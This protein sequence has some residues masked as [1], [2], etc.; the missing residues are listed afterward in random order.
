MT[1]PFDVPSYW[2]QRSQ[3]FVLATTPAENPALWKQFLDGAEESYMRHGVTTALEI[4]AIRD[5]STTA[6]FFA[7]LDRTGQIVG[8]VRV[9]GPYSSVDQSHALIEFADHPEGLRHVHTMLDERIGHG[10]VELKS[11]WVAQHAPHGRA[12]TAMIAESPAY[13]TALLGA[14]YALATAASH[15]R[16][17]WLDTGAVIAT[18][19]A[20]IPY[21]DDRYRTEVFWWDRTTLAFNADLAT[22]RRMR[23]NT[24]TLL[25]HRRAA[26][27]LPEAVAS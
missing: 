18:Q 9:Q 6:L 25:A 23:H 24:V 20:P 5:G 12:V 3:C 15:V 26:V 4:S 1:I 19:I 27:E 7:A 2:D 14:R 10:V 17:A 8:G 21:P 22:W 16:T 11:A 13:S